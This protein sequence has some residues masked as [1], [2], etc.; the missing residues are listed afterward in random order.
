MGFLSNKYISAVLNF[1]KYGLVL[2][3]IPPII[4]Y[5]ALQQELKVM[6][7]HGLF[8]DVGF[9]QKIFM[10]CKGNGVPTGNL[11]HF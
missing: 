9:G 8:Y 2:C 11:I 1:F 3:V 5:A 4:N 7:S 10:S 6:S